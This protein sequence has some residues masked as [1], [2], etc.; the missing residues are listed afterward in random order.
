[1][2][3]SNLS[4]LSDQTVKETP[5]TFILLEAK[6]DERAITTPSSIGDHLPFSVVKQRKQKNITIDRSRLEENPS[7]ST[8][9]EQINDEVAQSNDDGSLVVSIKRTR[10]VNYDSDSNRL[11]NFVCFNKY[12]CNRKES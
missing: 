3:L 11:I 4:E 8:I 1:M 5:N 7:N 12:I 6:E 2:D 9:S 10:V